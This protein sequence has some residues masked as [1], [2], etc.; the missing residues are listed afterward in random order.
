MLSLKG[1]VDWQFKGLRFSQACAIRAWTS[2]TERL[3]SMVAGNQQQHC[4]NNIRAG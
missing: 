1:K 3:A 4:S 2:A